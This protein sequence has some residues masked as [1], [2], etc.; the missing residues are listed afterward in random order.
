MRPS[1]VASSTA[2]AYVWSFFDREG[3][4]QVDGEKLQRVLGRNRAF[5]GV[6]RSHEAGGDCFF[7]KLQFGDL[8]RDVADAVEKRASGQA[9]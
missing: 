4:G 5:S 8:M 3:D 2:V 7:N 9:R 6:L 1:L